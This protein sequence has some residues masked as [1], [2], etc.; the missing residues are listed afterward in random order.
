MVRRVYVIRQLHAISLMESRCRLAQCADVELV[1]VVPRRDDFAI[2]RV[3]HAF[4]ETLL[5]QISMIFLDS[6]VLL[7]SSNSSDYRLR[8]LDT[9]HGTIGMHT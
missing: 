8:S 6:K 9:Y 4:Q 2:A 5:K 7:A 1:F 3:I